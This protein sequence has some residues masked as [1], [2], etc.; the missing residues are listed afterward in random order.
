MVLTIV[1]LCAV[2][3]CSRLSWFRMGLPLIVL[4]SLLRNT[5]AVTV[6]RADFI[7][8]YYSIGIP[9]LICCYVMWRLLK[10]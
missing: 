5:L 3:G 8:C 7:D 10:A 9:L 1:C 4:S 2:L 6:A